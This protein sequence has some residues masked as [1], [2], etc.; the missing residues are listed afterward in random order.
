MKSKRHSFDVSKKRKYK[1]DSGTGDDIYTGVST[2]GVI[3][4]DIKAIIGSIIGLIAIIAGIILIVKKSTRT[5]TVD[6][7]VIDSICDEVI[8]NSNT[9]YKCGIDIEYTINNKTTT[10]NFKDLN[11]NQFYQLGDTV[12]LWYDPNDVTNIDILSDNLHV[13]GWGL[14]IFGVCI[15]FFSILWAYLAN[16]YKPVAAA[17]GVLSGI[18]LISGR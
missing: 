1:L 6:G 11:S 5:S 16:K 9:H 17:E 3:M 7:I 15:I 8:N 12:T 18:N 2:F 10:K 13:F 14:L 4:S